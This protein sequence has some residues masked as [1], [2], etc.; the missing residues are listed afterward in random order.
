MK[1]LGQL[2]NSAR[3]G[4]N[5][6]SGSSARLSPGALADAAGHTGGMLEALEKR[7]YL[8]TLTVDP[9]DPTF[10]ADPNRPG[11]GTV[12][13]FFGYFLPIWAGAAPAVAQF[14]DADL[15]V[16]DAT[17]PGPGPQAT[18]P[19]APPDTF[20]ERSRMAAF[21]ENR[22]FG[23]QV[24]LYG[25][26]D[27]DPVTP[28]N[29]GTS[30]E[31][32]DL[33]GRQMQ[34]RLDIGRPS[35]ILGLQDIGT[36]LGLPPSVAHPTGV[37]PTQHDQ[38]SADDLEAI[39]DRGDLAGTLPLFDVTGLD[40]H[41]G[42]G[43]PDMND[44]IGRLN[45]SNTDGFTN[46][47]INGGTLT[48]I[49]TGDNAA[50]FDF[51]DFNSFY[52][53]TFA[54]S[55]VGMLPAMMASGFGWTQLPTTGAVDGTPAANGSV[56]I[57]SPFVRDNTDSNTYYWTGLDPTTFNNQFIFA[58]PTA[59]LTPT[60]MGLPTNFTT[61]PLLD[62]AATPNLMGIFST[63]T[64]P[65]GAVRINGLVMGSSNFASSLGTFYVGNLLGSVTVAADL[66]EFISASNVGF[67]VRS[68]QRG[69]ANGLDVTHA[70]GS[71]IQVGGTVGQILIAGRNFGSIVVTGN[72]VSAL[73]R[74]DT[75][76]YAERE[77]LLGINPAT[78]DAERLN[79]QTGFVNGVNL[80]GGGFY[81][82]D[83][84]AGAEF[85]GSGINGAVI[86]GSIGLFDPFNT[87]DLADIYAFAANQGS[88][89]NL[90]A[91]FGQGQ[92][93]GQVY[94]RIL[95]V[96]G[97]LVASNQALGGQPGND[98][99]NPPPTN[100]PNTRLVFQA[101]TTGIY[102]LVVG[103]ASDGQFGSS[104]GYSLTLTGQAAVTLGQIV[105]GGGG[106]PSFIQLGNGAMGRLAYAQGIVTGAG[107]VAPAA[108]DPTAVPLVD[109]LETLDVTVSVTGSIYDIEIGGDIGVNPQ[110]QT[111]GLTLTT[112]RWVG[113]IDVAANVYKVNITIGETLGSLAVFGETANIPTATLRHPGTGPVANGF[114]LTTGASGVPGNI[115]QLVFG[116]NV[117]GNNFRVTTS[118]GSTI[119]ELTV[120]GGFVAGEPTFIMGIGSDIRFANFQTVQRIQP[121][122]PVP[123]DYFI[124]LLY[125]TPLTL[126]D[127]S[128]V[129][130]TITINGGAAAGAS[131]GTLRVIPAGAVNGVVV[132]S[133]AVNLVGGANLTITT[134]SAG[135]LA[136]SNI[137]VTA[138]SPNSQIVFTGPAEIDVMTMVVNG[139][140]NSITNN[141]IGGDIVLVDV[142]GVQTVRVNG[143][144][145]RTQ[146]AVMSEWDLARGVG[147]GA[148]A[149]LGLPGGSV[150]IA[151]GL[152][153]GVNASAP[154]NTCPLAWPATA[155]IDRTLE[156]S[157]SPF[158]D[159]IAGLIAR[160]GN[161][162]LVTA[163]G[164]VGDVILETGNL[165]QV[166]AN[167]NNANT[168][169]LFEGIIGSIY[170]G[171]IANIDI[172]DGILPVGPSPFAAAGV[173]ARGNITM[174]QGGNRVHN[175]QLTNV[176]ITAIGTVN[177]VQINGATFDRSY[178][179]S[180]NLDAWWTSA[181]YGA[182]Q[183]TVA[184]TGVIN[185]I[186]INNG[187]VFRTDIQ[188]AN[189]TSINISHGSW[190]ATSA[191]ATVNIGTIRADNFRNSLTNQ[192][193][194]QFYFNQIRAGLDL[195]TLAVN[196]SSI[197]VISDLFF[198]TG[199]NT[200]Q[201][202]AH[203]FMRSNF[204]VRGTLNQLTS[205]DDIRATFITTGR[206]NNLSATGDI[207][208]STIGVSGLIS[209]LTAGGDISDTEITSSGP[210]GRI[211]NIQAGGM[212]TGQVS[213]SGP[214]TTLRAVRGDMNL[215]ILTTDG[216]DGNIGTISGGRDVI[217]HLT[218]AGNTGVSNIQAARHIGRLNPD[219]S[220]PDVI[221]IPGNLGNMTAG[222]VL[223]SDVH[224]GGTINQI[225]SGRALSYLPAVGTDLGSSAMIVASGRI[226]NVTINGDFDGSIISY[227]GGINQVTINNGSFRPGT[228]T[229]RNRIE[230]DDGDIGNVTIN[231]GHLL[232][233]VLA[234]DGSINNL[235][236]SG[237]A[238]FGN[239]GINP[240]LS[241]ASAAGVAVS[242][243]R[244]QL[245][246]DAVL[247]AGMDGPRIFAGRDIVNMNVAG[248][249]FEASIQAGRTINQITTA[250]GIDFGAVAPVGG[251]TFIVAGSTINTLNL[252]TS[253]VA[254]GLVRGTFI[255]AGIVSLGTNNV[256]GG[257]LFSRDVVRAGRI[258]AVNFRG[259]V[260]NAI[261][262]AGQDSGANGIYADGD[263]LSAPGISTITNVTATGPATNTRIRTDS[264]TPTIT[265]VLN[266]GSN[267]TGGQAL[268]VAGGYAFTGAAGATAI[269]S[270]G[271]IQNIGGQNIRLVF[272]GPGTATFD[273][274]TNRILLDG[275][276]T[277]STLQILGTTGVTAIPVPISVLGRDD[278]SLG[279][280][281]VNVDL[282][283]SL[284]TLDG[285]VNNATFRNFTTGTPI[286][287]GQSIGTMTVGVANTTTTL[288]AESLGEFTTLRLLGG[289]NNFAGSYARALNL[290][291]ATV[292]G[293]WTGVLTSDRDINS[294]Q[295]T[296]QVRSQPGQNAGVRAAGNISSVTFGSMLNARLSAGGNI[297]SVNVNGTMNQSSIFA[298]VD[299]GRDVALGGGGVNADLV[300]NGN[301]GTVNIGNG[302]GFIRS[303]IS[304]GVYPGADLFLGTPDDRAGAGR[305]TITSV[306][307]AGAAQ[308]SA[309]NT[310]SFRI[311]SNGTIGQVKVQNQNF[312][313]VQNLRAASLFPSPTAL[314]VVDT[315]VD[316]LGGV[317]T[318]FIQFN[319]PIDPT[320]LAGALS[321]SEI[322][323][324]EP[325]PLEIALANGPDY[326][327]IYDAITNTA[328][329]T[330]NTA[331]TSRDLV[332]GA[333]DP[334]NA[335]PGIYRFTLD[336][337]VLRGQT[338]ASTLDGNA[339]GAAT[340]GDSWS[341]DMVVG[342]A[343]D[344]LLSGTATSVLNTQVDFYGPI[345]LNLLMNDNQNPAPRADAPDIN[346]TYTLRGTLGDHPDHA[347]TFFGTASD[348][349]VYSISL[350]EGQV[351]RFSNVTGATPVVID[352]TG[353]VNGGL[354][355]AVLADGSLLTTVAGTYF[356]LVATDPGSFLAPPPPPVIT[357]PTTIVDLGTGGGVYSI[358]I[359]V[360][361]DGDN[362]FNG[363]TDGSDGDN[364]VTAPLPGA[365]AGVDGLLNTGDDLAF[366]TVGAYAF[367]LEAGANNVINGNGTAST[368]SDDRVVGVDTYGNTQVRTAGTDGVFSNAALSDD[369][370]ALNATIGDN[371]P[372]GATVRTQNDVDIYNLND[373]ATIAANSRYRITFRLSEFGGDLGLRTPR[374]VGPA[375]DFISSGAD[376]RTHAQFALFDVTTPGF[377]ADGRVVAAPTNVEAFGGT[378]NTILGSD[379]R[380]TYG[381]DARGDFY[382]EVTIPPR[383]DDNTQDGRFA[384]Y[385]QGA[386]ASNY[387]V[388]ITQL[389]N[390]VAP[391]PQTQNFLLEA[392]GG[393]VNWLEPYRSTNLDAYNGLT[394]SAIGGLGGLS[395]RDYVLQN[396]VAQLNAMFAAA[397]VNVIVDTTANAFAGQ[398]FSTVFLTDT[399]EPSFEATL[400]H[401]GV[402][403]RVDVLNAN[404]SDEAVVF[405]PA[406]AVQGNTLD[407]AGVDNYIIQM[408]AAIAQQ[409]G[410]LMGLRVTQTSTAPTTSPM[411]N[412]SPVAV[413]GLTTAD[414]AFS[415]GP[416]RLDQSDRMNFILG[417]QHD[418]NLLQRIFGV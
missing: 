212:F 74:V 229:D 75:I 28:G 114:R 298:G 362:G 312:T 192:D 335:A 129:T 67:W 247:T 388:E 153:N 78:V 348:A 32:L 152:I 165:G 327:V 340:S 285:Q 243:R 349:D 162:T 353:T 95:D 363:P 173:F 386:H 174:I 237:D 143:D 415:N 214:I 322:R 170:A 46:L 283:G 122:V 65:V 72:T 315:H 24:S 282:T 5:R 318:A 236:V 94:V 190:D 147:T 244:N 62:G 137:N 245:P 48:R 89:I 371:N 202:S 33:Y 59:I 198:S 346:R 157:G 17:S 284:V 31:I 277:S 177:S 30:V 246:S 196:N 182:A 235:N 79:A 50:D 403:Q 12:T 372:L 215:S 311:I 267:S 70:T 47:S 56:V 331:I 316:S 76:N 82:N 136:L 407:Q 10:V 384:L 391:T 149:A 380:T 49:D 399:P 83:A 81:R 352:A 303:N 288:Q 275:S 188:A 51:I 216:A 269:T 92:N 8:F 148:G 102:Y 374:P 367:H 9:G 54:D 195:A 404:R 85:V 376:D 378:P 132:G 418:V 356:I 295:I 134:T 115:G 304:A 13:T 38:V 255:G 164:A 273:A 116:G 167:N 99:I 26:I 296:G 205:T 101:P 166:V 264:G 225:Q 383:Q 100:G 240:A 60:D 150:N 66:G 375:A 341:A 120:A 104:L 124:P 36:D 118:N 135:S 113:H 314:Q 261:V 358:G 336:A 366:I 387:S 320:T 172:G 258:N 263:D 84:I 111:A 7:E 412:S 141:T 266:T 241:N 323:G 307:I 299:L 121:G 207:R 145:G 410:Q 268:P 130:F 297:N 337:D 27:I 183:D 343:G 224:V 392:S 265:P 324:A 106:R 184:P 20:V 248:G 250:R 294:V 180:A 274:G 218:M 231:R 329:I 393:T 98:A 144:L 197:G 90:D 233:D 280:L 411:Q 204:D 189:I 354:A 40:E 351:L 77:T 139:V 21:L 287:I 350:V 242:E 313:A 171:N 193:P 45:L 306:N 105:T 256:P 23:A 359:T 86:T 201:V 68:D 290:G 3:R 361:Q 253:G 271:I 88:T 368:R 160:T 109:Y 381:Y 369:L 309:F 230:A 278:A 194:I 226:N 377:F 328:R 22:M 181:R 199:R 73:P 14:T 178:I 142:G 217:L 15:G 417:T 379:G 161:V 71:I 64:A 186:Q 301:I 251:N 220:T 125:N 400:G 409:M 321:I 330:F 176:V 96:N 53:V 52:G 355:L 110:T 11:Y 339:N 18:N 281:T 200:N 398:P 279:T 232:G 19:G 25:A 302:G 325:L 397:G 34:N 91:L 155:A 289:L 394:L 140:V 43:V 305:S 364:V 385:V 310:E 249:I 112:T 276:T 208:S 4:I 128:G 123:Q 326:T 219:G 156:D 272:S 373:G 389:A 210:D 317:Y 58:A 39:G 16:G 191:R 228:A 365:F 175:P 291:S 158:G 133:M 169:G 163:G 416:N 119:D 108:S 6:F 408:S 395:V 2:W 154:F 57:G 254:N 131:G 319:Q 61:T 332:G 55:L 370:T 44:G 300:S 37:P 63:T 211:N 179:Y 117:Q 257:T 396:V 286:S 159:F 107:G 360:V 127:D 270:A 414:V 347:G 185:Q 413:S 342:D 252:G 221:D 333:P 345:N 308:G 168:S 213:S 29:Q 239:I 42:D 293:D 390:G 1:K 334:A 87:E 406:L 103:T 338:R 41:I 382:M 35:N 401:F 203:E 187:N 262:E 223:Y 260:D 126:T 405:A 292:A 97:R 80:Y 206:L 138:T 234:P 238:V 93:R 344:R 209:N 227:S 259:G 69:D 222:G 146:T 402:V 151:A 357:D